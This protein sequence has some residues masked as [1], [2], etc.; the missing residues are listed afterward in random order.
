MK[1]K[2]RKHKVPERYKGLDV[3]SLDL[4]PQFFEKYPIHKEK[5]T[6]LTGLRQLLIDVTLFQTG[7]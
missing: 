7:R 3:T 5:A 6:G 1:G 4:P 2:K